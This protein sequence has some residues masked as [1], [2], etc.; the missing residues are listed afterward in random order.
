MKYFPEPVG[1]DFYFANIGRQYWEG[2][3]WLAIGRNQKDNE[4][5]RERARDTD[6]QFD[7]VDFPGPAG[8]GRPVPGKAWSEETVEQAAA[9]MASFSPKARKSHRAV[10]VRVKHRGKERDV[11]VVPDRDLIGTW[12]IPDWAEAKAEKREKEKEH[13]ER[14]AERKRLAAEVYRAGFDDEEGTE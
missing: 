1:D 13:M 5:L 14:M 4:E 10:A 6:Y 11:L 7:L 8:V 3:H 12:K 2:E 9:L